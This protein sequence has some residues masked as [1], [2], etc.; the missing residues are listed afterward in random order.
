[1]QASAA[2]VQLPVPAEP[3]PAVPAGADLHLKD[4]TPYITPRNDF[5]RIDTALVVPRLTT[6]DWKLRIHGMV[7]HEVHLN[8]QQLLALP[9]IERYVTLSCVSNEVG[10]NLIGNARWLGYPLRSLLTQAVPSSTADMVLS[11]SIDGFTAGSPLAALTDGRDA[12]I[13]IA[14]DG[15]VL[16]QEHGFPARLVV[17]GLYGYVSAT[18]WVVD[19]EVTR[20]DK[21]QAYWTRRGWATD[22]PI[23][24]A[25]RIDVPKSF[26][27]VPAGAAVVAGVAWA[28]HRGVRG[29]E[30][31]VDDGP[32]Q[33]ARLA[34]EASTDTWRQWVYAWDA[35]PGLHNLHVRATDGTGATQPEQRRPPKPDGS[36]GW[37]SV[38]VTV[39]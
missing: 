26:A 17:P 5:Y 20:F 29:V 34:T 24:T 30:V 35:T 4:L 1:V 13:A 18:K 14:M 16:P 19:L 9:M 8:Y 23:H 31:Q 25:S 22:A 12:M 39:T 38:A 32:W 7:E 33:P 21:A 36:T 28:Q 27:R 2:A 15:K 11:R 6:Q 10:G 37:H 3:A